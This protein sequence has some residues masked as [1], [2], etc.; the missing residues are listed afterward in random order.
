M[1][2]QRAVNFLDANPGIGSLPN[3]GHD[4]TDFDVVDVHVHVRSKRRAFP[5]ALIRAEVFLGACR[6]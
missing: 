4:L 1:L 5:N 6:E 3:Y 2:A